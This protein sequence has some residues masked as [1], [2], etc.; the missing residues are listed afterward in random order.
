MQQSD[1]DRIEKTSVCWFTVIL[2]KSTSHMMIF[3][4]LDYWLMRFTKPT[5]STKQD[6]TEIASEHKNKVQD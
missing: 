4:I 1:N 3:T 2:I 6:M 5:A